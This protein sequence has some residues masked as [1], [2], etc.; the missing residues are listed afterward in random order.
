MYYKDIVDDKCVNCEA[1]HYTKAHISM[2]AYN[3]YSE[4]C[5]CDFDWECP[6][7]ECDNDCEECAVAY[8]CLE[9]KR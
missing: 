4:E 7:H 5:A 8:N 6:D 9:A 2:D 3:D 1:Y